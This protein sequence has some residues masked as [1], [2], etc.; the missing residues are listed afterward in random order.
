MRVFSVILVGMLLFGCKKDAPK[1]PE[2]VLLSLP[3]KNTEC[4]PVQTS[5]ESANVV[6]FT[7]LAADHAE[8]YELRV[9]NLNTGT[10]QTK[11]TQLL[12]ETLPLQKGTP[13]SWVVI[14]K[15]TKVQ[16]T[17]T[18]EKWMFYNP[19]AQTSYAPFPAEIISPK[20]SESVFKDINNEITLEWSGFDLDNDIADFDL[21]FSTETP[22]ATLIGTFASGSSAKKVSVSSKTVYYWKVVTKDENGNTSDSGIFSFKVF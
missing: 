20:L 7:W 6:R 10:T 1:S 2:A 4:A 13:F 18:S 12:S 9:T 17:S 11:S 14:S 16:K 22:P 3:A 19:G 15:N 21:Y 8:T 5:S